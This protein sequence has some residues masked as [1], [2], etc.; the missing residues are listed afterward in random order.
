MQKENIQKNTLAKDSQE[1]KITLLL[2]IFYFVCA[3]KYALSHIFTIST[4]NIII[5]INLVNVTIA[6]N[7]FTIINTPNIAINIEETNSNPHL[8]ATADFRLIANW[9]FIILLI[10]IQIPIIIGNIA[11]NNGWFNKII[12]PNITNRIP[13]ISSLLNALISASSIIY[14]IIFT[15]PSNKN[16]IANNVTT[17]DNAIPGFAIKNRET[18]INKIDINIDSFSYFLKNSKII[19]ILLSKIYIKTLY[20][21]P[22]NFQVQLKPWLQLYSL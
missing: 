20:T 5:P 7:G 9:N 10:N 22:Y 14:A 17:V 2:A 21:S 4:T 1:K 11:I 13:I 16:T 12:S 15:I 3:K 18:I 19:L 6:S 8:S